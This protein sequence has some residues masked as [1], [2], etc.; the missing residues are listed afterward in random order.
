MGNTPILLSLLEIQFLNFYPPNILITMR[1]ISLI[2]LI[3]QSL[4]SFSQKVGVKLGGSINYSAKII[5][6]PNFG[7]NYEH[8][9]GKKQL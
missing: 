2:L 4:N 8:K 3:F 5:S 1:K 9:L 7:I 6:I